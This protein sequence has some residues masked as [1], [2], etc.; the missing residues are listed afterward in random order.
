[1]RNSV[2]INMILPYSILIITIIIAAFNLSSCDIVESID[3]STGSQELS[4]HEDSIAPSPEP[5]ALN[6]PSD[7]SPEP[8]ALNTPSDPSLEPTAQDVP[9]PSQ[10]HPTS[11][12]GIIWTAGFENGDLSEFEGVGHFIFNNSG[13]YSLVTP[14]AHSGKYSAGLTIDTLAPSETRGHAAWLFQFGV[15]EY[16]ADA[17]YYSAWYY[18]PANTKPGEWWNVFQWKSANVDN[19]TTSD[20]MVTLNIGDLNGK[21]NLWLAYLPNKDARVFYD[22]E[23]MYIP[24]DQWFQIEAYYRRAQDQTGQVIVWQ[25]GVEIFNISNIITVL[26]DNTIRWSVNN[27]ANEIEPNPLTIYVDDMAISSTRLGPNNP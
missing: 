14:H 12:A 18:I 17:Y 25:D 26:S 1:M 24:T 10:D 22:Q 7:P 16:P 23:L 21:L 9:E 11:D 13:R 6:T 2:K 20:P 4:D 3:G 15:K 8:A 27:Y 5:A 19:D